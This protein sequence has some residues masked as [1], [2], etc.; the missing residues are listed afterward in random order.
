M[1]DGSLHPTLSDILADPIV[2]A[3]M[4]RDGVAAE[5]VRTLLRDVK[6]RRKAASTWR[7]EAS[8]PQM[9]TAEP[10]DG[11]SVRAASVLA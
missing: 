4:A 9:A 8:V 11:R 1:T 3:V 2:Q 5:D 7:R 6:R 10:W